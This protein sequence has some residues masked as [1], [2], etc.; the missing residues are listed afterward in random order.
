VSVRRRRIRERLHRD[1][2]LQRG[3]ADF[4]SALSILERIE[5]CSACGGAGVFDEPASASPR[6]FT[7]LSCNGSGEHLVTDQPAG[8][9]HIVEMLESSR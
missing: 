8:P 9:E 4:L 3:M 6:T 7:C 2:R 5:E 1:A